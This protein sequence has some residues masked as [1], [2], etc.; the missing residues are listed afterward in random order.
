[1]TKGV[2]A[3]AFFP[4]VFCAEQAA[5]Q[6]ITTISGLS[7]DDI[8]C[9][10]SMAPT[11]DSVRT[12]ILSKDWVPRWRWTLRI[13]ISDSS[14][15]TNSSNRLN[16]VLEFVTSAIRLIPTF[17]EFELLLYDSQYSA[18]QIR[19]WMLEVLQ[20]DIVSVR[21]RY[22]G[23]TVELPPGL[24][25]CRTL[26]K[27]KLEVTSHFLSPAIGSFD[28]LK[29]LKLSR[30]DIISTE[31][32]NN[33]QLQFPMLKKL[34]LDDCNWVNAAS[35][36]IRAPALIKF[37]VRQFLVPPPGSVYLLIQILAP[38]LELFEFCG[39]LLWRMDLLQALSVSTLNISHRGINGSPD[40]LS[41]NA[42]CTQRILSQCLMVRSLKLEGEVVE[43]HQLRELNLLKHLE[44]H[45]SCDPKSF[46]QFL[47]VTPYIEHIRLTVCGW[48][49]F[50]YDSLESLPSCV[51]YQLV[52]VEF[53]GFKGTAPQ[54]LLASF[55][56][57]NGTVLRKMS[58]LYRQKREERHEE[59][60]LWEELRK[61]SF[62][63]ELKKKSTHVDFDVGE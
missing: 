13:N 7:E 31:N 15:F 53:L 25:H 14:L 34:C 26:R 22:R 63:E 62:W 8:C 1:M 2:Y 21:I 42:S 32:P 49:T 51:V 30:I 36:A 60:T 54:C 57:E 43:V 44:F 39:Y 10:L 41:W 59:R 9:I 12:S 38:K 35:V 50:D 20:R 45:S 6:M 48:D 23:E 40:Y 19:N 18:E 33:L 55:F 29:T 61:Q 28:N 17:S 24:F 11:V 52:E 5:N 16:R 47:E 27:L 46:L 37:R 3:A 58:G 56:L 4:L